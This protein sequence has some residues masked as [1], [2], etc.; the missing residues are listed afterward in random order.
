MREQRGTIIMD[1][2]NAGGQPSDH[3]RVAPH[4]PQV[5]PP[6]VA[7]TRRLVPADVPFST[8]GPLRALQAE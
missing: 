1:A 6:L 2:R 8:G 3:K 5:R 4:D 7:S